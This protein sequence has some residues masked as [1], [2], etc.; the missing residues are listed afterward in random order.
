MRMELGWVGLRG[1]FGPN[2]NRVAEKIE[3]Y[4]FEFLF[5]ANGIHIKSFEYFQAK[6]ELDSK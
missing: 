3:N 2:S 1:T 6:F 4:F 5:Q